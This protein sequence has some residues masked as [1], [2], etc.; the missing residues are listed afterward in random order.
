MGACH[1]WIATCALALGVVAAQMTPV[2]TAPPLS[3][4]W[5]VSLNASLGDDMGLAVAGR[6]T[7]VLTKYA[8]WQRTNATLTAFNADTGAITWTAALA[9][10]PVNG[11]LE[12]GAPNMA[13][14]KTF[15][16]FVD[17]AQVLRL[18]HADSGTLLWT[19]PVP[20][21]MGVGEL[22]MTP[23]AD[24]AAVSV[25]MVTTGGLLVFRNG[26]VVALTRGK[27]NCA[28]PL[29]S[30]YANAAYVIM[31]GVREFYNG[32]LLAVNLTDGALLFNVSVGGGQMGPGSIGP[33]GNW[34][35]LAQSMN[36]AE[37]LE[38]TTGTLAFT[39]S[40]FLAGITVG[41]GQ[42]WYPEY[43]VV[44]TAS[45]AEVAKFKAIVAE[46]KGDLVRRRR[47][48]RNAYPTV[49]QKMVGN[50]SSWSFGSG[51]TM[52][53][54]GFDFEAGLVGIC[55]AGSF[56]L[57][58]EVTGA[59]IGRAGDFN[60]YG[61]PDQPQGMHGRFFF[62]GGVHDTQAMNLIAV[63]DPGRR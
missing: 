12:A 33:G 20:A 9:V 7:V 8:G 24:P 30:K 19:A 28:Y 14:S 48:L 22:A 53:A 4:A 35:G 3:L 21:G 15:V 26:A 16:A 59:V 47:N 60:E 13:T 61:I 45:A 10:Q 2:P 49:V 11:D 63:N 56:N 42:D 50:A 5:N 58:D 27:P 29:V 62:T 23:E 17:S 54:P 51:S 18:V 43:A 36:A 52:T 32:Q 37:V 31:Q 46:A 25:A 57:L 1:L 44:N 40:N 38:A 55:P 34:I 6:N 39:Y 41:R